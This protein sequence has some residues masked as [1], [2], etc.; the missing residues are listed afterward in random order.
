MITA[1]RIQKLHDKY[2]AREQNIS[3]AKRVAD[4]SGI[5][6]ANVNFNE[7]YSETKGFMNGERGHGYAG[8]YVN[9]TFDRLMQ[10]DVIN[11]GQQLDEHGRQFKHGADRIVNGE[12]IQTKYYKTAKESIGA[13]FQHKQA[14]Y[15]NSDGSM[16][17]IEVPRDQYSEALTIM[18]KRIDSGQVP[19]AEPG[20][21]AQN[22]VKKG[23][24]TYSQTCNVCKAG[25]LE[26]LSVDITS[27]II[28]SSCVGSISGLMVF[29][30]CIWNG[31]N[32][33]EAAQI[34]LGATL[35]TM[36]KSV[37]I[38]TLT[39]Q[40]SRD[41]FANLFVKK[42]TKDGIAAGF[43]GIANPVARLSNSL[44]KQIS[45][46]ALAKTSVGEG[47]G[48]RAV[49]GRAIISGTIIGVVVFGPDLVRTMRGRISKMQLLKNSAVGASSLAGAAVGQALIPIPVLGAMVGAVVSGFVSK[50]TLDNFIDDDAVAM[51][52]I[53]KEEFLECTMC[54]ALSKHEFDAVVEKTICNEKLQTILQ[55][56]YQSGLERQFAYEF[57]DATVCEVLKNRKHVSIKMVDEGYL[58]YGEEA[59]QA[60]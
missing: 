17:P 41:Q 53:F 36:G 51:F 56:M 32:I 20:T 44:A 3:D 7:T 27:G 59:L 30:A 21:P 5:A 15:L 34:S 50:K 43:E 37:L 8:E 47:L 19:N 38:Y 48:L 14:I 16:M 9:N 40:L 28:S 33:K 42:S 52:Q 25:T 1:D 12:A 45:Q 55:D 26:S 49:T 4:L 24:F 13:A 60:A 10:K 46:S 35:K 29:A 6:G 39:M 57:I 18:Q 58:A 11:A 22:F 2:L 31:K 54:M 23:W